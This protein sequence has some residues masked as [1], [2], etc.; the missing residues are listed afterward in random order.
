M[1]CKLRVIATEQLV[2]VL[3]LDFILNFKRLVRER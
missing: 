2:S 1:I 3:N